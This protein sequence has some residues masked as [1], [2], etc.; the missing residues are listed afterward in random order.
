MNQKSLGQ[1]IHAWALS[2]FCASPYSWSKCFSFF[3]I[4]KMKYGIFILAPNIVVSHQFQ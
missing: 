3:N 1:T 4:C 2:Y